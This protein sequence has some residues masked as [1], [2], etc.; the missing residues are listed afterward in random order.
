MPYSSFLTLASQENG[1]CQVE[2]LQFFCDRS[3]HFCFSPLRHTHTSLTAWWNEL[4][5][6]MN[7]C[8][9][10][11]FAFNLITP[12]VCSFKCVY[13]H[14]HTNTFHLRV[15]GC[16]FPLSHNFASWGGQCF[17]TFIPSSSNRPNR[18]CRI[19]SPDPVMGH[20]ISA[21]VTTNC[22]P[23]S[24]FNT[25]SSRILCQNKICMLRNICYADETV[26]PFTSLR[27]QVSL[28]LRR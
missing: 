8:F 3:Y 14:K 23:K 16:R 6:H 20:L 27:F 7:V 25:G 28:C 2:S 9:F 5:M 19:P 22:K 12:R 1:E 15:E 13:K 26:T 21:D 10:Y 17:L 11:R 24:Y 4:K 18:H